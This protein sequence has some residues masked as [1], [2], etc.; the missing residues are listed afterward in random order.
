[1]YP[2]SYSSTGCTSTLISEYRTLLCCSDRLVIF[3]LKTFPVLPR[4]H[5]YPAQTCADY[6]GEHKPIYVSVVH[7]PFSP[8]PPPDLFQTSAL[9]KN[10]YYLLPAPQSFHPLKSFYPKNNPLKI[11][12]KLHKNSFSRPIASTSFSIDFSLYPQDKK[13]QISLSSIVE[14]FIP[15]YSSA[16]CCSDFRT[17]VT[18]HSPLQSP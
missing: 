11:H 15:I 6:T 2:S 9:P 1:M 14:K 12:R 17:S 13:S 10:N 18:T 8:P 3:P 5:K 7:V 4:P 16:S